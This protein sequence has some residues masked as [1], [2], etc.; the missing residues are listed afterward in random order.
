MLASKMSRPPTFRLGLTGS[1]AMGKSQVA[2]FFTEAGINVLDADVIVHELYEA[3][4]EAVAP[5]SALFPSS[6]SASGGIDRRKLG[7]LVLGNDFAMKQLEAIVHPLVSLKRQQWIDLMNEQG[8]A[9]VVL[10]IPLLFETKL[11]EPRGGHFD[12]IA[13]VSAPS[14][15]QR[16]RALA[17]VGMSVEKFEA[18]LGKQMG[19][20]EKRKRADYI[21]NTGCSLDE[22]KAQVKGLIEKISKAKI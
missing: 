15:V 22:T 1:I 18:I 14:D 2:K 6:L 16:G 9:M 7:P 13:V 12:A 5:V 20:D 17:R 3:G 8:Q 11:D 10:D 19:D 21:I 4:G